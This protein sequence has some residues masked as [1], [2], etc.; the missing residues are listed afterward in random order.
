MD[1]RIS[2]CKLQKLAQNPLLE[3]LIELFDSCNTEQDFTRYMHSLGSYL[4]SREDKETK[5]RFAFSIYDMN[6]DGR[7]SN[8]ELFNV[9]KMLTGSKLTDIQIQQIVDRTILGVDKDG[10]GNISYDEFKEILSKTE[11]IDEKLTVH[12]E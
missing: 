11:D 9:L 10:S 3:R 2:S 1:F 7:I 12:I 4:S 8:G 5:L 6:G